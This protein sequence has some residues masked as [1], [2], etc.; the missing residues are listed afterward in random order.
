[1]TIWNLFC[2]FLRIKKAGSDHRGVC[3]HL[4]R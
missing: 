3:P 1:M 4:E 2:V